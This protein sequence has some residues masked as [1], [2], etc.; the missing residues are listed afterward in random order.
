MILAAQPIYK[1]HVKF[2]TH[3]QEPRM[4]RRPAGLIQVAAVGETA[5]I[6]AMPRQTARMDKASEAGAVTQMIPL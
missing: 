2:W 6:I 4:L 5:M 3:L 1:L